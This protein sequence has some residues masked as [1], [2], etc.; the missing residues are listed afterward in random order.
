[1]RD[2]TEIT[3]LHSYLNIPRELPAIQT[4]CYNRSSTLDF[5]FSCV[6]HNTALKIGAASFIVMK[7]CSCAKSRSNCVTTVPARWSLLAIWTSI[8]ALQ[9]NCTL[10]SS[11]R[12]KLHFGQF[13]PQKSTSWIPILRG[14]TFST[15]TA[16]P[17]DRRQACYLFRVAFCSMCSCYAHL[18]LTQHACCHKR[19]PPHHRLSAVVLSWRAVWPILVPTGPNS[20]NWGLQSFGPTW[21]KHHAMG[22]SWWPFLLLGTSR[23]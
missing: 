11:P 3:H 21:T 18:L 12:A 7:Q 8:L 22:C 2:P 16:L 20:G 10:P 1:M 14:I 15:E 23:W 4:I 6:C 17:Y 5:R 13:S 19:R 9:G